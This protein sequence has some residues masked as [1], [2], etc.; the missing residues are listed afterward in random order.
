MNYRL[1]G[2][3][4]K[5]KV[6]AAS[7]SACLGIYSAQ[8]Q[9]TSFPWLE[10]FDGSGGWTIV[11]GTATNQWHIGS[12]TGNP[13]NALY[14]SNDGGVTNY[15]NVS[16]SSV[17]HAYRDIT[18]PADMPAIDLSF[19]WIC[20]G[21]GS[22]W[23]YMRVWI[24]PTTYTPVAGTQTTSASGGTQLGGNFLGV[25]SWTTQSYTL[26]ASYAGTTQ[27]LIF[28]WKND[29][30][31]GNQPPAAVDN[32]NII[33][34]SCVKPT[35]LTASNITES[36]ATLGWAE[37][38]S[39][40][41][42]RVE[43]GPAG[44]AL[45]T[46][47]SILT[48]SNPL[49][50]SGLSTLSSYEFYVRGICGS[51]SSA[52]AGPFAFATTQVPAE[53][54]F[55]ESWDGDNEWEIRNGSYTNKWEVGDATGNPSHAL[56]ISNDGGTTNTYGLTSASTVHVFRDVQFPEG[57]VESSL[58]FD[59]KSMGESGYDY[60]RVWIVPSTFTP[61]PGTLITAAASGGDQYGTSFG[62][63]NTW[64]TETYLLPNTY[65][66]QIK[67]VV[68]EWRNDGSL[69]TQPPAAI[70]NINIIAYTCPRPIALYAANISQTSASVY[71]SEQG[72]ATNW[73]LE[74]GPV[75]FTPGTG[76]YVSL[77]DTTFDLSGLSANTTYDF[78][79][80]SICSSTDSSALV[81]PSSF[82]TDQIPAVVPYTEDWTDGSDWTIVNGNATNKW[83]VGNAVGNPAN[84]AYVTNDNGVSNAYS[85]GNASVVQIFRDVTFPEGTTSMNLSFDWR[86]Y[87]ESGYDYLRVWVTP[88]S[89]TPVAGT[90]TNATVSGGTQYGSSF[91]LSSS[92]TSQ[93]YALPDE[94]A[95]QTLR[96]IFEWRNDPSVGTQ[97]PAAIDNISIT[98][99]VP[100]P[101]PS[102][103][104]ITGLTATEVTL[105]W[106]SVDGPSSWQINYGFSGFTPG[107][108]STV[109]AGSSPYTITDLIPATTYDFYIRANCPWGTSSEWFGPITGT[110]LCILPEILSVVNDS[111]CGEGGGTLSATASPGAVIEW[112][113]NAL[114]SAPISEGEVFTTPS[115]S[116]SLT[117]YVVPVLSAGVCRGGAVPVSLVVHPLPIADVGPDR[118][119]CDETSTIISTPEHESYSYYWN[120]G[121]TT[122]SIEASTAGNYV[123][124]VTDQNMCTN[125]DGMHLSIIPL[126][127]IEGFNF[128]PLFGDGIR[129]VRFEPIGAS[130]VTSYYWDFGDGNY[131]TDPIP[132]HEFSTDAGY[133]ITLVVYNECG[134]DTVMLDINVDIT[135]GISLVEQQLSA[136]QVYPNP[137]KDIVTISGENDVKIQEV[138]VYN[139]LGAVVYK[140][141]GDGS[142]TYQLSVAQLSSGMY[143]VMLRTPK[144]NLAKKIQVVH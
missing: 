129:S 67:R 136:I 42:W 47:T 105:S 74:Y 46:G 133:G 101:A 87:G 143:T 26:P 41:T 86:N 3:F 141:N 116:T 104:N 17:V 94:Y 110:T 4:L 44:F 100:C 117:Y 78:Y 77:T 132:T 23:D 127:T 24:T 50:I 53:L 61:T 115:S 123:V 62:Q 40:T 126:P 93:S 108:G 109:T 54:P 107:T 85:V 97:P 11:N 57:V 75:G 79:V 125:S 64:T 52:L 92:W 5:N 33:V 58:S 8:A 55:V 80:R 56:Y 131:S 27:R 49:E 29:S 118:S 48:T 6:F 20:A 16:A 39:A 82:T 119:I 71:W 60:M 114:L 30:S 83:F 135:T 98:G 144:G 138:I 111:I 66:G 130:N 19:D 137:S 12:A 32:I 36:T 91:A 9:V 72:D 38:G 76:T 25:L 1:L 59:W 7:I 139:A 128:V 81:G 69:G 90:Q 142:S 121:A 113:E 45:G 95:G 51:D 140:G 88:T 10:E 73:T 134:S 34:S 99:N 89:Y 31:L 112:Y 18:F 13:A 28:E 124:T 37:E 43:Y 84:S 65:A 15:Y 96:F 35:A 14:V 63:N 22:A 122:S 120:T 103:F 106:S 68:F 102:A 2:K 70:D 21:E